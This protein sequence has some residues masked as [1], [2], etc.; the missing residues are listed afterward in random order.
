M[1][2]KKKV[3][4]YFITAMTLLGFLCEATSAYALMGTRIARRAIAAREAKQAVSTLS[5]D[6][7]TAPPKPLPSSNHLKPRVSVTEP[8]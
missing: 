7:E 6:E 4:F 1:I 5:E 2:L 8:Y 3:I